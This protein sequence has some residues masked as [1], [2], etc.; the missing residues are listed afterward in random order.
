MGLLVS[1]CGTPCSCS[2]LP[3]KINLTVSFGP[4][5]TSRTDTFACGSV[6]SDPFHTASHRLEVDLVNDP[7]LGLPNISEIRDFK[8]YTDGTKQI[9]TSVTISLEI[10]VNGL[11]VYSALNM[12]A[13]L[14]SVT[15]FWYAVLPGFVANA[16]ATDSIPFITPTDSITAVSSYVAIYGPPLTGHGSATQ[17]QFCIGPSF[18]NS[19]VT[20]P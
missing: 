3:N 19:S 12:P 1:V 14:G 7:N 2:S 13:T 15:E 8:S 20:N 17:L 11:D 16:W 18:V 4:A 6:V 10:K 5:T 9:P